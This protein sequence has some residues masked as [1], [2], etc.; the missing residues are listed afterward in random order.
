MSHESENSKTSA[1]VTHE[2]NT[3]DFSQ[4]HV[5]LISE[6]EP[7]SLPLPPDL[8]NPAMVVLTKNGSAPISDLRVS[9]SFIFCNASLYSALLKRNS[10]RIP[11]YERLT[12]FQVQHDMEQGHS[13]DDN[14]TSEDQS[15]QE[16]SLADGDDDSLRLI[17]EGI[18]SQYNYNPN[19]TNTAYTVFLIVNA[20]LGAG[21]LNFPKSYDDAGG[22]LVAFMVQLALLLFIMIAL[23]AL[24]YAS[25]KCGNGGAATIQVCL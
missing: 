13:N 10:Y 17:A 4:A 11:D 15:F 21:L 9:I 23:I 7:D 8:S 25:D 19:G 22:I 20:A 6:F 5:R 16:S 24:A 18:E 1:V 12:Y 2:F 14:P 3:A